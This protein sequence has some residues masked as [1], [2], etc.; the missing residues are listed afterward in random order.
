MARYDLTDFEW[1]VIE[2]LPPQKSRGVPREDD[3]LSRSAIN[4]NTK[5]RKILDTTPSRFGGRARPP[6]RSR[7]SGPV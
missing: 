2:P 4:P 6:G 7:R 3:R 5:V 1:S